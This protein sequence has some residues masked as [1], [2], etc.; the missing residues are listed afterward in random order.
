MKYIKFLIIPLFLMAFLFVTHEALA[1]KASYRKLCVG[2]DG[3]FTAPPGW[4][5]GSVMVGCAGDNG[6][7]A[8]NANQAC[9]GEVQTVK[10]GQT[11]RLTKCS[12][13]GSNKGCLIVG[14]TLVKQPLVGNLRAI[15]VVTKIQSISYFKNN[16][17]RITDTSKMCGANGKHIKGNFQITCHT[18][19]TPTPTVTVTPS[20]TVTPT[21]TSCVAP[22]KATNIHVSCSNCFSADDIKAAQ[23]RL[24]N[25]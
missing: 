24:N 22:K 20:P 12:C 15:K 21:P 4:K 13:F 11:F 2:I 7:A 3:K 8:P 17:C 23:D 9:S 25:N 10:P 19:P 5:G 6:R 16:H 1:A 14:K 18:S